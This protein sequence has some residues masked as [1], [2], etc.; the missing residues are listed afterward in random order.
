M[1]DYNYYSSHTIE[2]A[3]DA[4]RDEAKKWYALSERMAKVYQTTQSLELAPSAFTVIDPTIAGVAV[5]DLKG[6]Y[7]QMHARLLTLFKEATTQLDLFGD[8]LRRAADAYERSDANSAI[9][10]K[11]IWGGR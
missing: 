10:L 5:A 6:A 4:I 11:E 7:D 3:V 2:V 8:A 9:N 1:S